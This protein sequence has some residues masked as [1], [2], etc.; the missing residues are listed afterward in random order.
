MPNTLVVL[1]LAA[2]VL[3]PAPLQESGAGSPGR[4]RPPVIDVH[5]HASSQAGLRPLLA[6]M[7]SLGIT[8]ALVS[9]PPTVAESW[10]AAEPERLMAGVILPCPGGR[11]PNGGPQCFPDGGEFPSLEYLRA[12]FKSGRLHF[13]GEITTQYAGLGPADP[14]MEPY[15]ALAEELDIPV[16]IHLALGPP[17]TPYGCCPNFRSALGHPLQLEDV[18]VKHPRL[19]IWVMHAGYPYLAEMKALMHVY[20]QIYIDVAAINVPFILARAEFHHYLQGLMRAGFGKRIL[21][22][23]DFSPIR[24][25]VDAI[26]TAPFLSAEE[27][28]D[29]L[30]NN[31]VQ[32]LKLGSGT[33]VR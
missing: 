24:T 31:A 1:H 33:R 22:G 5:R 32:F 14:K 25:A 12:E 19:R 21:F 28:R 20:P 9:G 30:Y 27:R 18:L 2:A 29:I 4:Q 6:E 7:D 26:D 11:V 15:Y 10:V 17:G 3:S 13:L 8:L 23:S 16:A